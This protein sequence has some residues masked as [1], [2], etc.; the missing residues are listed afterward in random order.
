LPEIITTITIII[1]MGTEM[2]MAMGMAMQEQLKIH[3]TP[4]IRILVTVK[5][6]PQHLLVTLVMPHI[7]TRPLGRVLVPV[8][9]MA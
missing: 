2:A 3:R 6:L 4:R 8:E 9:P 7:F 5:V 1:L